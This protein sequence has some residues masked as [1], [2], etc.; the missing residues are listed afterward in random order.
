MG[1]E[2]ILAIIA[3]CAII[4][5]VLMAAFAYRLN[6]KWTE[7]EAT[8]LE[9]A[10]EQLETLKCVNSCNEKHGELLKKMGEAWLNLYNVMRR[11]QNDRD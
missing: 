9:I 1:T 6:E 11:E 10:E 4:A 8:W 3:A 5:A 7:R 2:T